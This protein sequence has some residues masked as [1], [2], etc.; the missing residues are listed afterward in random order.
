MADFKLIVHIDKEASCRVLSVGR[1][2]SRSLHFML[3]CGGGGTESLS[4][5]GLASRSR[6]CRPKKSVCKEVNMRFEDSN[7]DSRTKGSKDQEER[8]S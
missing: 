2:L 8:V 7:T 6:N 5:N 3:S 1:W 4:L